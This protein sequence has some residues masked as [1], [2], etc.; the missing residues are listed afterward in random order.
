MLRSFG[1]NIFTVK[2]FVV[3]AEINQSNVLE[4]IVEFN[5]KPRPRKKE[6]TEKTRN[7]FDSVNAFYECW[8]LTFNAFEQGIFPIKAMKGEKLEILTPKQMLQKF[9]I[10]L[11][12]VKTGNTSENLLNEVKQMIYSLY[13]EKEITIPKPTFDDVSKNK[14][15]S[16]QSTSFVKELYFAKLHG[17][18][19]SLTWKIKKLF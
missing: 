9:P 14:K 10:A 16:H 13:Q 12:Q 18:G 1:D 4:N 15:W 5:D 17:H 3:E 2:I 8:E 11:S 7:T 19:I 6:N